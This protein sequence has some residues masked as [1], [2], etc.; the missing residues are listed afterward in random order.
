MK[1]F[2]WKRI[3]QASSN[4]HSEGGVVVFAET[5]ARARELASADGSTCEI[6]PTELPD[7]VRDVVGG[8]E[9]VFIFCDAGCC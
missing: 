2:I 9:T 5:E 1:V 8:E 3:E 4:Y 7:E 6:G